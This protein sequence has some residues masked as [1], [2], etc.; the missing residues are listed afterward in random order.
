VTN[1]SKHFT[2]AELTRS[3]TAEKRHFSN[4]PSP[5]I[6]ANVTKTAEAM[7]EVRDLFGVPIRV[8]SGYRSPAVNQAV[9]GTGKS[10][11]CFGWAVD[12]NIPDLRPYDVC[13]KIA[14][15]GVVFDQLIHE[16]GAWTHIS[17]EPRLRHQLLT[18]A[19]AR[20]GYKAGIIA[21]PK[22]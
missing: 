17:F 12:F 15:S 4:V 9:G 3:A 14:A 13:R 8:S 18:I 22:R 7:E 1:L 2:L 5:H 16:Y 10:A 20:Q 6:L 11:H 21:I 19:N